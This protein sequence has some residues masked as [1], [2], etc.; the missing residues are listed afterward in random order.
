M[1][2]VHVLLEY[3]A[4]IALK[5]Q[6]KRFLLSGS[7]SKFSPSGTKLSAAASM[8]F[9]CSALKDS[10]SFERSRTSGTLYILI[11]GG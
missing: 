6:L 3:F 4:E 5:E 7:S 8:G 10:Y 11:G 2:F 9:Y 1:I